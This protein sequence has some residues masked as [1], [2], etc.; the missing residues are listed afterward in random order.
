[1]T[2]QNPGH[3]FAERSKTTRKLSVAF[4]N[5]LLDQIQDE[6]RRRGLSSAEIIREAVYDRFGCG[7]LG[8]GWSEAELP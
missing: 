7:Y 1:M 6:A 5:D 8:D 4:P 3:G 2:R